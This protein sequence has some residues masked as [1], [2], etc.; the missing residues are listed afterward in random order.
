MNKSQICCIFLSIII[1]TL[2]VIIVYPNITIYDVFLNGYW[3]SSTEFLHKSGLKTASCWFDTKE[4]KVFLLMEN[5]STVLLNKIV[6]FKLVNNWYNYSIGELE[7]KLVFSDNTD[8]ISQECT[9]KIDLA[10]GSLS[11]Y[12]ED[13]LELLLYKNSKATSFTI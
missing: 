9:I 1:V 10:N 2:I 3:E 4:N 7:C 11:L 5:E 13:T 8:P 12:N 6:D